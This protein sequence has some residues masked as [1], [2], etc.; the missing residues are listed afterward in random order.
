MAASDTT[1]STNT[2]RGRRRIRCLAQLTTHYQQ[3]STASLAPSLSN[4]YLIK[5][6]CFNKANLLLL[7]HL[8]LRVPQLFQMSPYHIF[9]IYFTYITKQHKTS[10][11]PTCIL[12]E[13]RYYFSPYAIIVFCG[14]LWGGGGGRRDGANRTRAYHLPAR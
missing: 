14:E 7:I 9:V 13:L 1:I 4:F 5:L 11:F 2:G 3:Q 6:Q 8:Y 12:P 10:L